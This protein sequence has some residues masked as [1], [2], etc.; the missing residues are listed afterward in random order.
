[1]QAYQEHAASLFRYG[2]AIVRNRESAQDA[3]QETFLR[4][5]VALNEGQRVDN[6]KAWLFRVLHNYMLD[7]IR[8]ATAKYE[9]GLE[10]VRLAADAGQDPELRF[11]YA[12]LMRRLW[13]AL[14]PRELECLRLRNEGFCYTE[15]AEILSVRAGT[16]GALLARAQRKMRKVLDEPDRALGG[17]L[18]GNPC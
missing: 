12:E 15:I 8:S 18:A 7:A 6:I 4:Y 5:F 2:F 9:T 17:Q 10:Q 3:V 11:H 16:V 1:M 14:A 13:S